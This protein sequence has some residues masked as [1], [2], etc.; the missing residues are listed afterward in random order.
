M[1]KAE[2]FPTDESKTQEHFS[3]KEVCAIIS[4]CKKNGVASFNFRGLALTFGEQPKVTQ[5]WGGRRA[6]GS[7]DAAVEDEPDLDQLMVEDP[8]AYERILADQQQDY[9]EDV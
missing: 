5:G 4:A 8:E 7:D 1:T 9:D 6:T 2:D 3:A